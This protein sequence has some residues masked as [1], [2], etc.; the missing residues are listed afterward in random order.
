MAAMSIFTPN[1][2]GL[3]SNNKG[4]FFVFEGI[5][6]SGKSTQVKLLAKNLE[7]NGH[8]VY[9][10]CEPTDGAIGKFIREILRGGV[11]ASEKTIAALFLAD[12]LDH[13]ENELNG[14]RQKVDEGYIVICD[15]YYFSSYAYHSAHVPL[16][17]V[18]EA[19]SVC[20]DILK[21]TLNIF[22]DI[23][24]QKSLER[25]QEGREDFELF[26]NEERLTTT[27]TQYFNAFERLKDQE[28]I[29]IINADD[30]IQTLSA[31]ILAEVSKHL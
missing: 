25:I 31:N 27:R 19:N 14:L 5:D 1:F 8:K 23:S 15:R 16:S 7:E 18:I 4:K 10:T 12:R 9:T 6:G 26:E 30:D 13:L 24:P 21:P 11:K 28:N 20:A 17:W 22:L 2:K 29:T 3:M